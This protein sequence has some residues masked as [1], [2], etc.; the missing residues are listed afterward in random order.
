ML[1]NLRL[2]CCHVCCI[3]C[4]MMLGPLITWCCVCDVT[5]RLFV[6]Y[7]D[8]TYKRSRDHLSLHSAAQ[9]TTHS[10]SVQTNDNYYVQYG[11]NF[12]IGDLEFYKQLNWI[13]VIFVF[14]MI[15]IL[16]ESV[17]YLWNYQQTTDRLETA[18]RNLQD[19]WNMIVMYAEQ[20]YTIV[21]VINIMCFVQLCLH[22]PEGHNR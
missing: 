11:R 2:H 10:L 22:W 15:W 18:G 14:M 5:G 8:V 21:I 17:N 4:Q 19:L 3:L 20:S 6:V 7:C 9:N 1:F 13:G 12:H 16:K